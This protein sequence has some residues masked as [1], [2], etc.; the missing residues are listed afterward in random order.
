M[1]HTTMAAKPMHQI[2]GIALYNDPT[3]PPKREERMIPMVPEYAMVSL[4]PSINLTR[5]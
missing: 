5:V 3:F 4:I 1:A 2:P